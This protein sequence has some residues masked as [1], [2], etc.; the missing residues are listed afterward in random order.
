M[1][2][3][4]PEWIRPASSIVGKLATIDLIAAVGD[5]DTVTA[6][7]DPEA[8]ATVAAVND[9]LQRHNED[10]EAHAGIHDEHQQHELWRLG[11]QSDAKQGTGERKLSHQ[12]DR[13]HADGRTSL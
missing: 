13:E 6:A 9:L 12:P 7:I 2:E 4:E 1:L 8:I 10:P 3:N 11:K 5:V